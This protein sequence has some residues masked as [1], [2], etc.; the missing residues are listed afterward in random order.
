MRINKT[1]NKL[2]IEYLIEIEELIQ[3]E[4]FS[5]GDKL[6]EEGFLIA[7]QYSIHKLR[8]AETLF[9]GEK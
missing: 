1:A 8:K 3:S 7:L 4:V 5:I 6:K 9:K 2:A